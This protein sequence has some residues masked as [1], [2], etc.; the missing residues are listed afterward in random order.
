VF[1]IH[2]LLKRRFR[3]EEARFIEAVKKGEVSLNRGKFVTS[4]E[5]WARAE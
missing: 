1:S 2:L 3:D 5:E 4:E